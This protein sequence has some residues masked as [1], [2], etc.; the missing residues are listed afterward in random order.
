MR[1]VAILALATTTLILSNGYAQAQVGISV[2]PTLLLVKGDRLNASKPSCS[3]IS[4][5]E[6]FPVPIVSRLLTVLIGDSPEE[7]RTE[8]GF[9]PDPSSTGG[10]MLWTSRLEG[11]YVRAEV[12]F[13]NQQVTTRTVTMATSYRQPNEK[14]CSWE[15]RTLQE[16]LPSDSSTVEVK[17]P[18]T[19]LG[20]YR[21]S[22]SLQRP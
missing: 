4:N 14:Q 22:N 12:K 21:R 13:R 20:I 5:N 18:S 11:Q 2:G 16:Q 7:V 9:P 19:P 10:V 1:K 6:L 17:P 3:F 8:I 15:V